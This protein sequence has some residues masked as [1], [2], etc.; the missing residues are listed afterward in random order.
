[1]ALAAGV[2]LLSTGAAGAEAAEGVAHSIEGWVLALYYAQWAIYFLVLLLLGIRVWQ[3]EVT[4]TIRQDL[5]FPVLVTLIITAGF[6]IQ[7][8]PAVREFPELPAVGIL[9]TWAMLACG[10]LAAM[11]GLSSTHRWR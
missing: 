5:W 10:L 2:L 11:Y 4:R 3:M 9:R 8:I 6:V 7:Y 1:M